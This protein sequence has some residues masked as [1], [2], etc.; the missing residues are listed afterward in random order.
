MKIK[1]D[2]VT[3]SSSSSFILFTSMEEL[4]TIEESVQELND[5]PDAGDEGAGIY[6]IFE[7]KKELDEYTNDGPLDWASKPGGPQF[8]N[9]AEH[10]Y[11]TCL[12]IIQNGDVVISLS[13]DRNVVDM[14]E[15]QWGDIIVKSM[16]G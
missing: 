14:F 3:N 16:Y 15:A 8:R 9:F 4:P 12:E 5:H 7:T 2:F 13:V 6:A 11:I 10:T 1:T